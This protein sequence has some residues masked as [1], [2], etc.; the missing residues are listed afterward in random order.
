MIRIRKNDI[1]TTRHRINTDLAYLMAI[2]FIWCYNALIMKE[3]K[4]YSIGLDEPDICT[5]LGFTWI[6]EYGWTYYYDLNR[7]DEC[8]AYGIFKDDF[9]EFES[10]HTGNIEKF[11]LLQPKVEAKDIYI[12]DYFAWL[13]AL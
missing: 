1:K 8:Q 5:L 13:N 10:N 12:E 6:G 4:I 2:C 11:L 9:I 7:D 3:I